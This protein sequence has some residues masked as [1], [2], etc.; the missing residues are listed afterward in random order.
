[1]GGTCHAVFHLATPFHHLALGACRRHCPVSRSGAGWPASSRGVIPFYLS[2]SPWRQGRATATPPPRP[3]VRGSVPHA[4]DHVPS[5]RSQPRIWRRLQ[6]LLFAA[7]PGLP[8]LAASA[9]SI[10]P[11]CERG[12]AEARPARTVKSACSPHC[13]VFRRSD[14]VTLVAR[15]ETNRILARPQTRHERQGL[16]RT[17]PASTLLVWKLPSS[18]VW[19]IVPDVEVQIDPLPTSGQ[20]RVPPYSRSPRP[21]RLRRVPRRPLPTMHLTPHRRRAPERMRPPA[22]MTWQS[23]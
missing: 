22:R 10:V 2:G 18:I 14:E 5:Q 7:A 19:Q 12:R 3:Q 4:A 8:D 13:R 1:M 21:L 23:A 20:W 9:A 15:F 11:A 6:P 16:A 17:L